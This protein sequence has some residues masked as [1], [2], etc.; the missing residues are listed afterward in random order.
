MRTDL[1]KKAVAWV[2]AISMIFPPFLQLTPQGQA[3]CGYGF[4]LSW[5][6]GKFWEIPCRVDVSLLVME[7][8]FLAVCM[9]ALQRRQIAEA[10]RSFVAALSHNSEMQREAARIQADAQNS[11]A[12]ILAAAVI[13]HAEEQRTQKS[14]F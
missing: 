3:G 2:F 8:I 5:P 11:A 6:T 10:C 1:L 12:H 14:M 13:Q 4:L 9:L 7:W